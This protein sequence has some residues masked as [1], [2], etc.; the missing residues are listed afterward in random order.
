MEALLIPSADVHGLR[1]LM[2]Q[3]IALE[4]GI[5]PEGYLELKHILRKMNRILSPGA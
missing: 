4:D 5:T 3:I 1:E 2:Q